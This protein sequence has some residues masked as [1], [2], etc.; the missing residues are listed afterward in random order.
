MTYAWDTTAVPDGFY[1]V[2]VTASD[3]PSNNPDDALTDDRR[4]SRSSSIT[5]R[6]S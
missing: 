3:R 6:R 4:A 1:R 5:S 2:R